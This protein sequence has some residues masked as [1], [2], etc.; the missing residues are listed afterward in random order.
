[1]K[2]QIHPTNM[3]RIS[4][5]HRNL[6]KFVWKIHQGLRNDFED[7]FLRKMV[8]NY[9]CQELKDHLYYEEI[10]ISTNLNNDDPIAK[11][12]F[13]FHML[14]RKRMVNVL[15]DQSS[16]LKD[17]LELLC[18]LLIEMVRYEEKHIKPYVDF[19]CAS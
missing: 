14:L 1:M 4:S 13:Q 11:K 17:D 19:K 9:W 18:L 15:D 10:S 2:A 5:P 8:H 16:N 7:Q 6:L 12:F 3:E